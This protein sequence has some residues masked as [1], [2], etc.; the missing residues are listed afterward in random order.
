MKKLSL[1]NSVVV[2]TLLLC[3]GCASIVDGQR[4]KITI[5][6]NPQGANVT[7]VDANGY[8]VVTTNT[9]A[10]V[11][12][13]RGKGYFQGQHYTVKFDMPGYY[14]SETIIKPTINPW[15][16]GNIL[17][18]GAIGIVIVDP[19]TGAMW[20]LHPKTVDRNLIATTANLT[21]DQLKAADEAANPPTKNK[22]AAAGKTVQ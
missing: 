6:S 5:N 16:A 8:T 17:I 9:P 2:I 22:M 18:G 12:L 3:S 11:K 7:I 21:P 20:T 10:K 4:P 1:L 15:Y 13:A 14:P 19:L